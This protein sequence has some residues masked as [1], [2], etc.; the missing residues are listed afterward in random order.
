M[1]GKVSPVPALNGSSSSKGIGGTEHHFCQGKIAEGRGSKQPPL[2]LSQANEH[3]GAPIA[4]QELWWSLLSD[5][6]DGSTQGSRNKR[7]EAPVDGRRWLMSAL[8]RTDEVRQVLAAVI[9]ALG[10]G[11]RSR[12]F[13]SMSA[14]APAETATAAGSA[15]TT[16]LWRRRRGKKQRRQITAAFGVGWA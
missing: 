2:C 3:A 13:L 10:V 16:Q 1:L 15:R 7:S 5:I 14:S 11:S 12:L 4:P 6:A 8:G 9:C